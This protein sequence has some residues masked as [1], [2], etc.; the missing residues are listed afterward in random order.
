[1]SESLADIDQRLMRLLEPS[2]P[3]DLSRIGRR[4]IG[5]AA[6]GW[7]GVFAALVAFDTRLGLVVALAA[8]MVVGLLMAAVGHDAIHL[9][10]RDA[11][12]GY[13][14][15]LLVL[16][17]PVGWFSPTWWHAKHNRNHHIFTNS[18]LDD[19][20]NR[21][22]RVVAWAQPRKWHRL[23]RIYIWLVGPLVYFSFGI[24]ALRFAVFGRIHSRSAD[25][26]SRLRR[27]SHYRVLVE[28]T[29]GI[30]VTLVL[31][32]VVGLS[33]PQ[34]VLFIFASWY[35][36]GVVWFLVFLP[37]HY[38]CDI[39]SNRHGAVSGMRAQIAMA[40]DYRANS[41]IVRVLTGGLNLH[42]EHHVFPWIPSWHLP[43]AVPLLRDWAVQND[44]QLVEHRTYAQAIG[45]WWRNLGDLSRVN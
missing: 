42:I 15:V 18:A 10:S 33:L 29:F 41:R 45:S 21:V 6:I 26:L 39:H 31:A 40:C 19:D 16:L 17:V 35:G 27:G 20:L 34:A 2:R 37:T 7:S 11:P 1:V 4:L 28:L 38:V 36:A 24:K 43:V 23:Q 25:E 12:R 32:V 44:V 9:I 5:S 14:W 30:V 3:D 13:W 22:V 8:G